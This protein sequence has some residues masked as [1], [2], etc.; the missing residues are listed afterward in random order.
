[1]P[2]P[3]DTG[4]AQVARLFF[5]AVLREDW[6]AAYDTL[7]AKSKAWCGKDPFAALGRG[8]LKQIDFTPTGVNVSTAETGDRATA[9]A[10]F[11][12]SSGT[13]P[14]SYKDGTSL[15]KTGSAWAVVLNKSFGKEP[16]AP[17]KAAAPGRK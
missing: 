4:S 14:R 2:P 11:H 12:G 15:K 16:P 10:S 3:A 8:Y 5:E 6:A 7:D 17:A 13:S 9:I 1:V